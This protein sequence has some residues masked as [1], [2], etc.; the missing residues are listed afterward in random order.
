[1]GGAFV[2]LMLLFDLVGLGLL[3]LL[4]RRGGS[5]RG[6]W[7]WL[8]AMPL[9]GSFSLLRFDLVPTTIAIAALVVIHR[10]PGW[11]GALAGLGAAIKAWPVVLLLGE[12]D[13][14]RLLPAG[15]AAAAVLALVFGVSALAFGDP[16]SFLGAQGGRGLQEEAVATLPWQLKA[17]VTGVLPQRAIHYGAWQIDEPGAG[18]VATALE[19]LSAAALAAAAAWWWLRARAIRAGQSHLAEPTVSRDFVFTVVLLLVVTSRVL[20]AQ[21]MVWLVGLAAI[22]LS[23]SDTRLSRPAWTVVAAAALTTF[24]FKSPAAIATRDLLLLAAA[25]DASLV[26]VS[27]LREVRGKMVSYVDENHRL[28]QGPD[29]VAG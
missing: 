23:A 7:V 20:S 15:V 22:V 3:A 19:L 8:L 16:A 10:R 13:R 27:L 25:A 12:W 26:M 6:F 4:A 17:I 28:Q 9:L 5:Y 29:R 2:G 21:Y 18:A 24:L 1:Y 11:F 14:R